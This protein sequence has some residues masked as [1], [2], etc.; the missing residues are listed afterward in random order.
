MFIHPALSQS[1]TKI[2]LVQSRKLEESYK[3][4]PL[5]VG[6]WTSNKNQYQSLVNDQSIS[7]LINETLS[8]QS[9]TLLGA[10][11]IGFGSH[12]NI[13]TIFVSPVYD[14]VLYV[15]CVMCS[16]CV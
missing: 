15:Y 4:S 9:Y 3:G 8:I 13:I 10:N 2:D 5:I 12:V 1:S 16:V 11:S 14:R 7:I 6:D